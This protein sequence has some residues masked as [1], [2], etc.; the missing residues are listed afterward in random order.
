[1]QQNSILS[2]LSLYNKEFTLGKGNTACLLIHG[3]GCGPIQ[4]REI[5]ER[6][7]KWGFTARG[8]LLPGHC[9]NTGGLSFNSHHD[10]K[11]KVEFEYRQLKMKYRQVVIIGLVF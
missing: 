2:D 10:W 9:G 11:E 1:M 7:C 6:L 8:I 3:F 5:A 4:M